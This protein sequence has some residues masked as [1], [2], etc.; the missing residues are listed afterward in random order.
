M[1]VQERTSVM[2]RDKLA[3]YDDGRRDKM[4]ISNDIYT[5]IP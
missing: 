4:V 2:L 3:N 1:H 5:I